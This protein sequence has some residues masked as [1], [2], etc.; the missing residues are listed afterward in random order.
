MYATAY[1]YNGARPC[2]CAEK[3]LVERPP[4][5]NYY[6][7]VIL[8]LKHN[9]SQLQGLAHPWSLSWRRSGH[10]NIMIIY[11]YM[12]MR[13]QGHAYPCFCTEEELEE[14]RAPECI[15]SYCVLTYDY[16]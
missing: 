4:E 5:H 9:L 13:L 15:Y 6:C 1:V 16:L 3:G 8:L 14:K 12:L 10:C 11:H 7:N 2:F